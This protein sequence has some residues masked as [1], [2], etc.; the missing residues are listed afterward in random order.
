MIDAIYIAAGKGLKGDRN[1]GLNRWP[2]QN[3]TLVEAEEIEAF[4]RHYARSTGVGAQ[5]RAACRCTE[6]RHAAAG[7]ALRPEVKPCSTC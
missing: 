6:R 4:N 1:F 3:L 7:H 5:V 2:G